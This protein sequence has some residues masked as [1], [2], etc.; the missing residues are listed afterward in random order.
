MS[1]CGTDC[2]HEDGTPVRTF[3]HVQ[4]GCPISNSVPDA[5]TVQLSPPAGVEES[6]QIR[7]SL[8]WH[9]FRTM[10]S[11]RVA[12][13]L[14]PRARDAEKVIEELDA[15][16]DGMLD[17]REL[18]AGLRSIGMILLDS[19]VNDLLRELHVVDGKVGRER[20][21]Q[22]LRQHWPVANTCGAEPGLVPP[23]P[24]AGSTK[25]RD[26]LFGRGTGT[27]S[28]MPKRE[29][30]APES[31]ESE[32][33]RC[34]AFAQ[35]LEDGKGRTKPHPELNARI[36]ILHQHL[37]TAYALTRKHEKEILAVQR[38]YAERS[39][40]IH[41]AC[42]WRRVPLHANPTRIWA[43]LAKGPAGL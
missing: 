20:F 41:T 21:L 4:S 42:V 37:S 23:L 43:H 34:A 15:N 6:A 17:A 5:R 26:S 18:F 16:Q 29:V 3:V 13:L 7:I 38:H 11:E 10:P 28:R 14:R 32:R 36:D 2:R 39:A 27:W 25:P 19:D 35:F 12:I 24:T 8:A 33:S 40:S 31:P 22:S 30:S 9:G 1:H